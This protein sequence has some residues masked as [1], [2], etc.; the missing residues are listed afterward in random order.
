MSKDGD[1]YAW[2]WNSN[3]QL[4]IY[5]ADISVLAA[6]QAITFGVLDVNVVKV[7]CGMRHTVA[8]LGTYLLKP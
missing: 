3:G 8:I 4:G 1:L 7:A 6:P 2:G 5:E